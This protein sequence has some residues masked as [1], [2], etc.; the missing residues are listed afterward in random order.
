MIPYN[1]PLEPWLHILYQDDHI[2]V[3]NK[4]SEL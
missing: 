2:I 1:P 4:P 3:V